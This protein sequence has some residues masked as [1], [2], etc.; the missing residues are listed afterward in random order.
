MHCSYE[1][2]MNQKYW[3][4]GALY[5]YTGWLTQLGSSHFSSGRGGGMVRRGVSVEHTGYNIGYS[6]FNTVIFLVFILEFF[7]SCTRR[8]FNLYP[9]IYKWHN[10]HSAHED[11]CGRCRGFEPGRPLSQ[12]LVRHQ[13]TISSLKPTSH[14]IFTNEPPHLH[15]WA[16]TSSPMRNHIFTNEA[17]HLHPWVTTSS[18]RSKHTFTLMSPHIFTHE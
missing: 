10:D 2:W 6:L 5:R 3:K 17:P 1:E 11:R 16:T 14:P 4:G 8:G 18:P 13:W 12:R 7:A 15:Q 9:G